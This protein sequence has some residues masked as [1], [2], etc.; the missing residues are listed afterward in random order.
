M[1]Q[2][3]FDH[4]IEPLLSQV[5]QSVVALRNN[6]LNVLDQRIMLARKGLDKFARARRLKPVQKI[7]FSLLEKKDVEK[8]IKAVEATVETFTTNQKTIL[9]YLRTN[10]TQ[11]DKELERTAL[12]AER[13]FR[14]AKRVDKN[15]N[16]R[17]ILLDFEVFIQFKGQEIPFSCGAKWAYYPEDPKSL[18][19]VDSNANIPAVGVEYEDAKELALKL[20]NASP[21]EFGLLPCR[22][23]VRHPKGRTHPRRDITLVFKFPQEYNSVNSLRRLLL[24]TQ[25]GLAKAP[26]GRLDRLAMAK[27]LVKAVFSVHLY[28]FVHKNIRP[29]TLMCFGTVAEEQ[30]GRLPQNA[31]LIGFEVMRIARGESD[32]AQTRSAQE[33]ANLYH[34][35]QRLHDDSKRYLTEHDVYSLGVCLLEIGLWRSFVTYDGH[36]AR[37]G[38]DLRLPD[39]R[40]P[41]ADAIKDHFVNLAG[42]ELV[43]AMGFE[44]REVVR[45]CLTCLDGENG[46]T[47]Q[48]DGLTDPDVVGVMARSAYTKNVLSRINNIMDMDV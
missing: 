8:A 39:G 21:E 1:K 43:A 13:F 38:N 15:T 12:V 23:V 11:I 36:G 16:P 7:Q 28:D 4:C 18:C 27:H 42:S 33:A 17:P 30:S 32:R 3:E 26:Q 24:E 25:V 47:T 22:G 5:P 29:E 44:Y 14:E 10:D 41:S 46:W 20:H 34:H 37:V 9:G 45:R 19:I 2:A 48:R 40:I 6:I 31:F 35:P